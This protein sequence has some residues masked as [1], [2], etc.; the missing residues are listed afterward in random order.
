MHLRR[1][2]AKI[3]K[4]LRSADFAEIAQAL[5]LAEALEMP[6]LDAALHAGIQV[7]EGEMTLEGRQCSVG[8]DQSS[9][10]VPVRLLNSAMSSSQSA[11]KWRIPSQKR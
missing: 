11:T 9:R 2:L 10:R 4:L 1:A 3:R 5:D 7:E 6:E 8:H